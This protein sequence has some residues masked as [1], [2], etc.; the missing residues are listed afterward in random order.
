[1]N[2]QVIRL[3][4]IYSSACECWGQLRSWG[5]HTVHTWLP[6][7]PDTNC[8][9]RS[10]RWPLLLTPVASSRVHKTTF[11]K[12]HRTHW[13]LLY[14]Q[15]W[16]IWGKGC[17]LKSANGRSTKGR[18]FVVFSLLWSQGIYLPDTGMWHTHDTL[19]TDKLTHVSVFKVF[20][21]YS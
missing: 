16:F 9:C 20:I 7:L 14:S 1:M 6:L 18:V 3:P 13:N 17:R 12:P 10:L 15:L 11:M 19:P 4:S 8:K 2:F 21:V 5:G